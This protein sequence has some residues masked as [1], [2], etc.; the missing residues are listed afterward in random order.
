MSRASLVD[1]EIDPAVII[2][3]V[4]HSRY[5]AVATFIGTVREVN[6]GRSV[7]AI[8]YSAYV[9]MAQSE[10]DQ[11]VAEAESRFE[12]SAIVVEHRLGSLQLGDISI[13]IAAAHE[14]RGPALDATRFVIEQIKARV[15]IWKL[16]HYVDG[17]REWVD[18][19][20]STGVASA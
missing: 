19:T 14:H 20:R 11:I 8:D 10:M 6:E 3:E 2:A 12:I 9:A 7:S 18:P 5:G 16:E 1:R 17:A 13:A 15:P 4:R